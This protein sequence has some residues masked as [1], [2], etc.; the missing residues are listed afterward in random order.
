MALT[1]VTSDLI[2]GLDYSK[3]TGTT[4][5]GTVPTWN[6]DTTGNAATATLA[7]GATILATA[8]N[9]GGVS[10]NG[11][12]AIDLPGVNTAGNQNTS[13][14]AATATLLATARNINS[15]A[16][17]GSADITIVDAT[18]LPLAGRNLTG[19][20]SGTSAT[21]S[22]AL[23]TSAGV[24]INSGNGALAIAASSTR[25]II[26][27]GGT[28]DNFLTFANKGYIG[29][30]SN[31]M[32]VIGQAGVAL[33]LVSDASTVLS[34][35]LTT[36]AA[37]FS[38][39]IDMGL[40][41]LFTG[42]GYKMFYR[43]SSVNITYSG[44]S[45]WQVN[46]NADNVA[47]M[48]VLDGGNVGIGTTSP[49]AKL[50]NYS[51]ATTNVFITGYGTAAQ[52][53]WQAQNAFFVKTDNGILISKENANNNTNRLFNFYNNASA[54]ASMY[55]YRG[56][57][58]S[59]IKLDT[60]GDSYLNGGNVGIGRTNPLSKLHLDGSNYNTASETQFTI[61]DHGNNYNSGDTS[62]RIVM[63]SRY[64]SGDDNVAIRSAI[65]NIKDNGNGSTG[66]AMAFHTTNQ[67]AGAYSEKLRITSG[68][69]VLIG[70]TSD[71]TGT[72]YIQKSVAANAGILYVGSST[73]GR[74]SL[75]VQ[76]SN[77]GYNN[78][79][80]TCLKIGGVS[81]TSRSISAAG[82]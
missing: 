31:Y 36:G 55:M 66:S 39:A 16:F 8:R 82:T 72:H 26:N 44:T 78:T 77:M 34:F 57:S 45:N 71:V 63:E 10:F 79:P 76:A 62:C 3:L 2:H 24:A 49:G 6:Q 9:I 81:S 67:G 27:L 64:W 80:A 28:T 25:G 61:T 50:H 35:A 40:N 19:A 69:N 59:Y 38:G 60:N 43:N 23:A 46:N 52:N 33:S 5:A 32:Q 12:A 47:L 65:T 41:S 7:A 20:L 48:T 30:G 75:V 56:G 17:D 74:F 37:T 29:V 53:N 22:G 54:E 21:F 73:T 15:V 68:G 11:S 51:T 13:G 42:G 58:T 1:L 70:S 4:A 14:V 18:K